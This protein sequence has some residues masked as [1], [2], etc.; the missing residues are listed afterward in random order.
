[1]A[2][3]KNFINCHFFH[4]CACAICSDP[5]LWFIIQTMPERLEKIE[6]LGTVQ[7]CY[8]V[9]FSRVHTGARPY[10]CR[11]TVIQL[12]GFIILTM[13]EKTLKIGLGTVK[14]CYHVPFFR[15]HTGARPYLALWKIVIT[16]HFS[17]VHTG[18]RPY[19][20][21]GC[22]SYYVDLE[23]V[24][25]HIRQVDTLSYIQIHIKNS[26]FFSILTFEFWETKNYLRSSIGTLF[27]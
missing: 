24:K 4:I 16:C 25:D 9:P 26:C 5:T 1:M 8:K 21:R 22:G 13:P 20:C 19:L 2:L 17:R 14:N 7:N 3:S 6:C 11:E 27:F 23:A 12:Y 15:V 10:L 18:A